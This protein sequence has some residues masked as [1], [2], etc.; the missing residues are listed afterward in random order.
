MSSAF[1]EF[2]SLYSEYSVGL[3][4]DIPTNI[5]RILRGTSLLHGRKVIMV[6]LFIFNFPNKLFT[7]SE[8]MNRPEK[9]PIT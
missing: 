7:V 2:G 8:K 9:I 6:I 5:Q 1:C 3:F 4:L